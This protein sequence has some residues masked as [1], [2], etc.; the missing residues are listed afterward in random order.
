MQPSSCVTRKASPAF[1]VKHLLIAVLRRRKDTARGPRPPSGSPPVM[2]AAWAWSSA[3][4][5]SLRGGGMVQQGAAARLGG[6]DRPGTALDVATC[7]AGPLHRRAGRLSAGRVVSLE[8]PGPRSCPSQW[9]RVGCK[10]PR[11]SNRH[12]CDGHLAPK[13]LEAWAEA[14]RWTGRSWP[15]P[16]P[17]ASSR[18]A[19]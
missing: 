8:P 3:A 17:R 15:H 2:A 18:P 6:R 9:P 16:T 4:G 12:D 1:G 11:F 13:L 5:V 10:A 14:V 19:L 7:L